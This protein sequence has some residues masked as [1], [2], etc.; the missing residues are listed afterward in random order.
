MDYY[1]HILPGKICIRTSVLRRDEVE[2]FPVSRCL[3]AIQGV[4]SVKIN[5]V[6]GSVL[7]DY[8]RS[9]IS[10]HVILKQLAQQGFVPVSWSTPKVLPYHSKSAL[11]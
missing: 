4:T 7:I 10:Y 2:V 6:I 11:M 5:N 9:A 1:M 3:K 8:D